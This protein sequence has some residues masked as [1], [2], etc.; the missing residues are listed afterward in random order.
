MAYE[1]SSVIRARAARTEEALVKLLHGRATGRRFQQAVERVARREGG[2]TYVQ[3]FFLA[4]HLKFS[5][6]KAEAWWIRTLDHAGKLTTRLHRPIDFRIA[7]LDL[8]I[9]KKALMRGPKIIE[10]K[11]FQETSKASITDELTRL[12]NRRHFSGV[13]EREVNRAVRYQ[14]PLSLLMFDLDDFKKF[15]DRFGHLAG[16]LALKRFS[17][18]LIDELRDVDIVSRIGGEEFVALLPQTDSTGARIAAERVRKGAEQTLGPL[19]RRKKLPA[20]TVS[21][22]VA[23]VDP[24]TRTPNT[25]MFSADMALYHSKATGKNTVHASP[26]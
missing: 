25:L 20:V 19:Y 9:G 18:I 8:L 26:S 10:L 16:D 6:K 7:L 24:K 11:I 12:Y 21:A 22:G 3:L 1:E 2:G 14:T 5:A 4:A 23:S 13:L 15:N 17:R